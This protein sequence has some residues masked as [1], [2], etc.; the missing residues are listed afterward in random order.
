MV[1]IVSGKCQGLKAMMDLE[2]S[3]SFFISLGVLHWC[4]GNIGAIPQGSFGRGVLAWF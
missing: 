2:S 4:R 3:H 1:Q